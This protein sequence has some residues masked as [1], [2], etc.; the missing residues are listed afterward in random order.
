M[1]QLLISIGVRKG[2]VKMIR[3]LL[4]DYG[5]GDLYVERELGIKEDVEVEDFLIKNI[6]G[7]EF[8]AHDYLWD[9]ADNLLLWFSAEDE[10]KCVQQIRELLDAHMSS[11]TKM[12]YSV[13]ITDEMI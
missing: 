10:E 7:L 8:E 4:Y 11:E 13:E 5:C 12:K 2:D 9:L 6:E 3:L 1:V